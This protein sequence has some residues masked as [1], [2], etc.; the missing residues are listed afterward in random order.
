MKPG[1]LVK[2]FTSKKGSNVVIR[3]LKE[4]DLE[5]LLAYA[6]GLIS[7]DTYIALSGKKITNAQEKKY[8][9][10][11]LKKV[12]KD[13]KIHLVAFVNDKF[14]SSAEVRR[15]D[16]RSTHVGE[17]GIAISKP[18]REEGIGTVLLQTLIDEAKKLGLTLLVLDCFE[19]NNLALHVYQKL[20]FKKAGVLPGMFNYKNTFVGEVRMYLA[21]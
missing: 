11:S 6:N 18:F 21:I 20:G 10:E 3:Y 7:E 8:V 14:A 9:S 13:E 19:C 1:Q 4:N 16:R 2:T 5:D 15:L 12:N 17:I